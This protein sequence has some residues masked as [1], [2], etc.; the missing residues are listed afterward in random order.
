MSQKSG[1]YS[2]GKHRVTFVSLGVQI[3]QCLVAQ[4]KDIKSIMAKGVSYLATG[5][6]G[7]SGE[8]CPSLLLV[9]GQAGLWGE[10]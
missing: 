5:Q 7:V 6:Y 1:H 8:A 3:G 10:A 4:L 2:K 9:G